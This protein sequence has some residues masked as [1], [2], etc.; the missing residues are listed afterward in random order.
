ME[1]GVLS[2]AVLSSASL[3]VKRSRRQLAA[4]AAAAAAYRGPP[5]SS[6]YVFTA[7]AGALLLLYLAQTRN[8]ASTPR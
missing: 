7:I 5:A 2:S 8:L 3:G 4:E 6:A 1:R